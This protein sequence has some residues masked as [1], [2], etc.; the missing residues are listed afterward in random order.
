MKFTSYWLDTRT[1]F[2]TAATEPI[3]G[4]TDVVVIGGGFTGLA[5]ALALALQGAEVVLLEADIVGGAASGR[6]GGHCHNGFFHDYA[7][8]MKRF[9]PDTAR[10]VYHSYMTAVDVV[11]TIVRDEDID[12]AFRRP[13]KVKLAV[14][15]AAFDKF[16][17][18]VDLVNREADPE[19]YTVPPERIRD[20]V[21][22]DLFH[23]GIIYPR[24]AMLHVGRF[25]AGMAEAATRHGARIYEQ[26][27]VTGLKRL[28]GHRYRVTTPK[29]S[30]EADRVVVATGISQKG[31][32]GYF[33]RRIVPVGS[34]VIAT[35]QLDQS[36][37]D[38]I[39]PRQR[40][41]SVAKGLGHYY[42][43]SPDNRLLFGGRAQFAISS[44]R[45]DA[46]SG[47]ILKKSMLEIHPQLRGVDIDYCWG[48]MIEVTRDRFPRLGEYEGMYFA[49][50][51]SGSGVQQATHMGTL[52]ARIIGG[53]AAANP[54]RSLSW[55]PI[56]GHFGTP[57]FLPLVGAWYK[58][59]E[60]MER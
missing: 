16:R 33:R 13:G 57:W 20:E 34:F 53:E 51:Y 7:A 26:T 28:E 47:E 29:G 14:T 23:G 8:T 1:A 11:E 19:I 4:R 35:Q 2:N 12:C 45:V 39:I 32:L 18:D 40:T 38:D 43:V 6:N 25:G 27:A 59:K 30:I 24:S 31:P 21:G 22:S 17:A 46:K 42:R 49:L 3:E 48:G 44:P 52:L 54:F 50:G 41:V 60:L 55:P 5:C 10:E 9:G 58:A 36:V 56:P 37:I 15:P